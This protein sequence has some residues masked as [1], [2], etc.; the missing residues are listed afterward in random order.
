MK[1]S[2]ACMKVIRACICADW[3][4]ASARALG[5]VDCVVAVAV[6]GA[7]RALEL[8]DLVLEH[9]GRRVHEARVDRAELREREE[10]L[11]MLGG[12][13]LERRGLEDGR[14][15]GTVVGVELVAVVEGR[16]GEA[17][18]GD[19][20]CTGPAFVLSSSADMVIYGVAVSVIEGLWRALR[21]RL[22][23]TRRCADDIYRSWC[24]AKT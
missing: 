7:R 8:G 19:R 18:A 5:R 9:V 17:L 1:L 3:P 14:R 13:E 15:A 20:S 6:T 4:E 10:L 2:P 21:A 22:R 11:A 12:L 23:E 16:G 24:R